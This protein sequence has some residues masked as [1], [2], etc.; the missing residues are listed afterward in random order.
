MKLTGLQKSLTSLDSLGRTQAIVQGSDRVSV[1]NLAHVPCIYYPV[2]SQKDQAEVWALIDS[3]SEVRP[4]D[5]GAQKIDGST[6]KTF[7]S[8]FGQLPG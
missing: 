6:L 2:C 4:T 5:V 3:R 1:L 7:G 8:V